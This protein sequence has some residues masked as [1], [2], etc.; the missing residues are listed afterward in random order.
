MNLNPD[1]FGQSISRSADRHGY[2]LLGCSDADDPADFNAAI[3]HPEF[4]TQGPA[5]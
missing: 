5:Q 1:K 4:T 3:T 2:T